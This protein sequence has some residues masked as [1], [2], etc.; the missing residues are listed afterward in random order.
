MGQEVLASATG[1][2][3]KLKQLSEKE[4]NCSYSKVTRVM[5]YLKISE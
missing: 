1:Q 5:P 4:E 2:E 3:R